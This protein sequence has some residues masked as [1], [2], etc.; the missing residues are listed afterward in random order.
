VVEERADSTPPIPKSANGQG[1]EPPPS[2]CDLH[3]HFHVIFLSFPS[4]LKLFRFIYIS[5]VNGRFDHAVLHFETRHV[6]KFLTS[7]T[8]FIRSNWEGRE[9]LMHNFGKQ[10][11]EKGHLKNRG[12]GRIRKNNNIK[13]GLKNMYIDRRWMGLSQGHVKLEAL[14]LVG[15]N[16]LGLYYWQSYTDRKC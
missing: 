16:L 2:S 12:T 8:R 13:K 4:F 6:V 7:A 10:T 14:V 15:L 1:S 11:F 3:N 9:N 5:L